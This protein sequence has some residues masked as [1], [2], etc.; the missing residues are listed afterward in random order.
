MRCR[1]CERLCPC[2][3]IAFLMEG[4]REVSTTVLLVQHLSN[5]SSL[6]GDNKHKSLVSTPWCRA[7][8]R[9]VWV[10]FPCYATVKEKNTKRNKI[11]AAARSL[12]WNIGILSS[13]GIWATERKNC[14]ETV[15]ILMALKTLYMGEKGY[16][17]F[18]L[19]KRGFGELKMLYIKD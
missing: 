8:A 18:S 6:Q 3:C 11:C 5:V 14:V 19:S 17:K 1:S 12:A 13:V 10:R 16:L 2:W 7:W 9:G 4:G 15:L